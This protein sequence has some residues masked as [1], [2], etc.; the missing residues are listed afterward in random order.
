[1]TGEV[2]IGGVFVPTLL[3]LAVMAILIA[4]G[5]LRIVNAFGLHR[6]FAYRALVDLAIVVLV[7]GSLA[8]LL[9]ALGIRL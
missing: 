4:A 2:A 8:A 9:P 6:F 1:M 3:I 7:L 5:L